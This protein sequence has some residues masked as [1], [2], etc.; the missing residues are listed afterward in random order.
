[1]AF[2]RRRQLLVF[3]RFLARVAREFGEAAVLKGGLS[4]ELRLERARTT[5]DVD[6]RLPAPSFEA[7]ERLRASGQLGLG[8]FMSF[9]VEANPDHPEIVGEGIR[10]D[11]FRYRVECRLAG[12]PYAQPFG[13]DVAFGDPLV[14]AVD[15][16]TAEDVLAFAGIPPPTLRLYPVETHLAERLHAY[17]QPR[18]RPNSRVK[19][20]PDLALLGTVRMLEA[21]PLRTAMERVFSFRAVQPVPPRLPAPP[22]EWAVPFARMAEQDALP[23]ATLAEMETAV[24]A[25]LDPVLAGKRVEVWEPASWRWR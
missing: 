16:V 12:K 19:D 22:V 8:D 25:F 3:D 24:R 11:G 2:A 20:L 5:R 6:L 18:S 10:Y 13:V 17:T 1:V 15:V 7:L 21:G 14:G 23:W 9:E 4:L